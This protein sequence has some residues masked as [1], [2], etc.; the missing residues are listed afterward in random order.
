M[1]RP[2][3]IICLLAVAA[4]CG[5]SDNGSPAA[6]PTT[7]AT[8][9]S[10]GSAL[11]PLGYLKVTPAQSG[12]PNAPLYIALGDSLS[13]GVGASGFTKTAFVPLVHKGLG[14]DF[15][16]LNLGVSGDTSRDLIESGP[17]QRAVLEIEQRKNDD[18]KG[19]EVAAITLEIGGNDLLSIY[20]KL[21]VP[22][23]CPSVE[24]GLKKQRCVDALRNALD[25]YGPNLRRIISDLRAADPNIPIFL[26]TLYN[27]FSG[28][29]NFADADRIA[30]LAL[31]GDPSTPFPEGLHDII[32]KV[33]AETGVHLVEVYSL[34]TGKSI[35]YVAPDNIHPNDTGY[36]LIADAVLASMRDA[37]LLR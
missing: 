36:R 5:S 17:L 31:E 24:E 19:N 18:V 30:E 3:L 15:A 6:S 26:M 27:P 1:H 29:S 32:R 11:P 12:N 9:E 28:K 25:A 37:G 13:A 16:L 14:P 23:I 10:G 2:L 35:D 7:S 20:F 4:A 8:H 33:A 22:G 34:F 21:V